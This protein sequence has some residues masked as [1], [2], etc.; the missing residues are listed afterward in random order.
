MDI[1][2]RHIRTPDLS[3]SGKD[4]DDQLAKLG[5][6]KPEVAA[7]S[8]VYFKAREALDWTSKKGWFGLVKQRTNNVLVNI[9]KNLPRRVPTKAKN[10]EDIRIHTS[11]ATYVPK[12][13]VCPNEKDPYFGHTPSVS[14]ARNSSSHENLFNYTSPCDPKVQYKVSHRLLLKRSQSVIPFHKSLARRPL[15]ADYFTGKPVYEILDK[16]YNPEP[17][18][19]KTRPRSLS[20]ADFRRP[21]REAWGGSVEETASNGL[22]GTTYWTNVGRLTEIQAGLKNRRLPNLGKT[23]GREGHMNADTTKERLAMT[24]HLDAEVKEPYSTL[25]QRYLQHG[26]TTGAIWDPKDNVLERHVH[27]PNLDA[28]ERAVDSERQRKHGIGEAHD[29]NYEYDIGVIKPRPRA[30]LIHKT[31]MKV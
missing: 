23:P 7:A 14:M 24:A 10:G 31:P 1:M 27:T 8:P 16:V 29:L 4:F 15:T 20:P 26:N 25:G 21:G 9:G 6:V 30:A 11:E 17:G 22:H 5:H 19:E 12:S 2:S 18:L 13:T 3:K 28:N